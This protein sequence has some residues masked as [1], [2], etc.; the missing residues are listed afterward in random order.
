MLDRNVSSAYVNPPSFHPSLTQTLVRRWSLIFH[1]ILA[2]T[3]SCN[4][5]R[6]VTRFPCD[7]FGFYVAFIYLQKGIQVLER[8][9]SGEAFYLSIVAALLVFMVAYICGMLGES[10]LFTHVVRVF[11]KDYGTPL[12]LIFFTGFVYIG[13]MKPVHLETLPTTKAFMPT[14][15]EDWIV[16]PRQVSVGEVFIA[17]P[18]G[19]LLTILFWFDH[20]GEFSWVLPPYPPHIQTSKSTLLTQSPKFLPSLPR[21]PSSPSGSPPAFTGI[22]SFSA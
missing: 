19:I 15:R 2:I 20:N 4:L 14:S 11:L 1:W 18:F 8:L 9:G 6:Y 10:S 17:M 12:T 3:N 5:L 21:A 7:I 16:D 13:R 22:S